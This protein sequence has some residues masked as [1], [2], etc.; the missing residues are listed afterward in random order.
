VSTPLRFL[1][2]VRFKVGGPRLLGTQVAKLVVFPLARVWR[3]QLR[4]RTTFVAIT[5]SAGKTTAKRL[6][7]EVLR[8]QAPTT[9]NRGSSNRSRS[10]SKVILRTRKRHGFCVQEF[11]ASGPGSLQE[12]I[13]GFE[14]EVAL[15]TTVGLEHM[16]AFHSREAVAAEKATLVAALPAEGLAVLNADDPLVRAMSGSARCRVVLYGRSA[17]AD[18]RAEDVRSAWPATLSFTLVC[19]GARVPVTT[20][21]NGE[22]WLPSALGA[23]ATGISLGVPPATAA[24]ALTAVRPEKHRLSVR[25]SPDG[26]T[27]LLDDWKAPVWTVQ[28][29]LDVLGGAEA[30]RKIAV[31]GQLSDDSRAPRRLYPAIARAAR[32]H[33]DLVVVVGQWA[34]H[35][36]RARAG[37]DDRSI[38]AFESFGEASA[39]LREA[40]RPGDLV[41]IKANAVPDHLMRLALEREGPVDCRLAKCARNMGCERCWLM[42][43]RSPAMRLARRFVPP[44]RRRRRRIRVLNPRV[45]ASG[46]TRAT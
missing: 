41:L 11:G 14:P 26:P 33:A 37:E 25:R 8:T 18:V 6:L 16:S 22:H 9:A 43:G 19:D 13:W 10:I 34:P 3:R 15:V 7:L 35:G 39:F 21:L 42:T 40:L 38:V 36:L 23:L 31:I 27:F 4:G 29:A 45:R 17:D 2:A 24:A 28:P 30:E 20:M 5:G 12:L 44:D 46:D 32:A 1:E